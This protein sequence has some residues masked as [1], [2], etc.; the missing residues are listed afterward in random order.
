MQSLLRFLR[1]H[2][3][4][5]TIGKHF[6]TT[7]ITEEFQRPVNEV[8]SLAVMGKDLRA[9]KGGLPTLASRGAF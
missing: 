5:E 3:R 2:S 6:V 7:F 1:A 8:L 4:Q 9:C